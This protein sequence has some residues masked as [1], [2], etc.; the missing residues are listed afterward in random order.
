MR[1]G[2]ELIT[3]VVAVTTRAS[4]QTRVGIA[5]GLVVIGDLVGSEKSAGASHCRR[6]PQPCGAS[7]SRG[8]GRKLICSTTRQLCTLFRVSRSRRIR[9]GRLR[10]ARA[11]QVLQ[12][13][14]VE[15][16]FEAMRTATTPLVGR[17]EEI[18][19][20]T[21]RWEQAKAGD[22]CVVLI[23]GEPGIG[24]SRMRS[25]SPPV[26]ASVGNGAIHQFDPQE[27]EP[28]ANVRRSAATTSRRTM[29]RHERGA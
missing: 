27:V 1:A 4:L 20:L 12:P 2:L 26:P 13:S 5:T 16:R 6:Y 28:L 23:A 8:R 14:T 25:I 19:L 15:S 10:Y 24:K 11:Y 7:A 18:D 17:R 22:G 9:S 29:P 21:R 3:A